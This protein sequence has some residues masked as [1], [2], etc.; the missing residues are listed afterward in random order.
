MYNWE[1]IYQLRYKSLIKKS[2]ITDIN[3]PYFLLDCLSIHLLVAAERFQFS[4]LIYNK[5]KFTPAD[6]AKIDR[7]SPVQKFHLSITADRL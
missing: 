3:S 4:T 6:T 5:H 1:L 7:V 2:S